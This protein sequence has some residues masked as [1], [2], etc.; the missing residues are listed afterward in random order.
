MFRCDKCN[1]VFKGTYCNCPLCGKRG[2]A[3][4]PSEQQEVLVD[5]ERVWDTL[6]RV[7]Y[8]KHH[9]DE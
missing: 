9:F 7:Q 3:W 8:Y 6:R 4:E 5:R 1:K 2:T